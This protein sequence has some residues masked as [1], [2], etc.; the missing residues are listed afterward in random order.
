MSEEPLKRALRETHAELLR[1]IEDLSLVPEVLPPAP[2]EHGIPRLALA[3]GATARRYAPAAL[4]TGL[5]VA[6]YG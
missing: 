2:A 4:P 3:G 5:L 6:V 1:R